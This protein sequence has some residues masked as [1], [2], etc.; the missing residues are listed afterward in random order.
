[1]AKCDT[2]MFTLTKN[3]ALLSPSASSWQQHKPLKNTRS[4]KHQRFGLANR[5]EKR[6][7]LKTC[8]SLDIL[9]FC[10]CLTSWKCFAMWWPWSRP[11][12][13][14]WQ[15]ICR[16]TSGSSSSSLWVRCLPPTL[17]SRMCSPQVRQHLNF[18]FSSPSP[19]PNCSIVLLTCWFYFKGYI[20]SENL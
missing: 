17:E 13:L 7:A 2:S 18:L 4:Y 8:F 15:I 16:T 5:T 14:C 6:K 9:L 12:M 19:Y 11:D 3:R 10:L 20:F 1:M